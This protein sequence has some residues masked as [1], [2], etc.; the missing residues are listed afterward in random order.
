MDCSPVIMHINDAQKLSG[1][2]ISLVN[3]PD[4]LSK[5]N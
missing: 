5:C 3:E 4:S 1:S 2:V